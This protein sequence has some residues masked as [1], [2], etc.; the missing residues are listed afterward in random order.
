MSDTEEFDYGP[1]AELIWTLIEDN[2]HDVTHES[3]GTENNPY[4]ETITAIGDITNAESQVLTV[5]H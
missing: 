3:D 4:Y 2:G 5:L 1:L